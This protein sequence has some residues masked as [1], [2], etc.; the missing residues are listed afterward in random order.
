MFWGL[1]AVVVL[2]A[3]ILFV[4][5]TLRPTSQQNGGSIDMFIDDTED[6]DDALLL[7]KNNAAAEKYSRVYAEEGKQVLIVYGTEYGFGEE[8]SKKLFD[9]IY[10]LDPEEHN[11]QPRLFN[12]R[13]KDSFD[14]HK[15]QVVLVVCS[16]AGD[17]DPPAE[18]RP[19]YDAFLALDKND[20]S[21]SHLRYSVLAL[22]DSNYLHFCRAGRALHDKFAE[23]G[24]HCV[25]KRG[26]VDQE[27]WLV[28]DQWIDNLVALLPT[29]DIESRQ[30]YITSRNPSESSSSAEKYNR[31][32][33]YWGTILE[34]RNLTPNTGK[35]EE[36]ELDYNQVVHVEIDVGKDINYT[37]GDALGIYPSNNP[38]DVQNILN[39]L[40]ISSK[41]A[42]KV[43]VNIPHSSN[44]R[45][46]ILEEEEERKKQLSKKELEISLKD[47]LMHYY[48]LKTVKLDF[49]K[50]VA[51]HIRSESELQK[52]EELLLTT[53][54]TDGTDESTG[55][56][57]QTLL[58]GKVEHVNGKRLFLKDNDKL[59]EYLELREVI[60]VLEDFPSTFSE[61]SFDVASSSA[62]LSIIQLLGNMRRMQPRYYSISS[63][64][65]C[66]YNEDEDEENK[67]LKLNITAAVVRYRTL[68]K[69]RSGVTTTFLADRTSVGD[70][71]P[72][73]IS[74][75]EHFRLPLEGHVPIIMIGPGTGIAPFRAFLQ[76]RIAKEATGENMLYFGCRYSSCD[77]LYRD[78]FKA[79]EKA[80]KL[81]L[82]TAF[83]R[84][85]KQKVYVQHLIQEDSEKIW[86]LLENGAHVY[87]CGDAKYMAGDVHAALL[88]IIEEQQGC[89]ADGAAAYMRGL[90]NDHRYQRDVWV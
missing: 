52:M 38:K 15:E 66:G 64:P 12:L 2:V 31:N 84:D 51:K 75:N 68:N 20:V 14:L 58:N 57:F 56:I 74:R 54:T 81:T 8:V 35:P 11:L 87:V 9:R 76:E 3:V 86:Q 78:E 82:R 72:V 50:M 63:S 60:D 5:I 26:D 25:E 18:A 85:Q 62:S 45:I 7:P 77:F 69:E 47:A 80:G 46:N 49:L 65:L 71:L 39:A 73:F 89:D 79:L 30:D 88:S 41:Q 55:N 83:S 32:A 10:D 16:T 90:E 28:I 43:I 29:L 70:R 67:I 33:P 24:A 42:D 40:N 13:D 53:S 34:M 19:F 37:S 17:G 22:G 6:E 36:D 27:D 21:L 59:K 48:D 61:L 1:I 4:A 23:L 44:F